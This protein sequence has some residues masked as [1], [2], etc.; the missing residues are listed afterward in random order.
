M[1][2]PAPIMQI[3]IALMGLPSRSNRVDGAEAIVVVVVCVFLSLVVFASS[4][5]KNVNV[6]LSWE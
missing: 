2:P 3:V 5:V 1:N 4:R 6:W